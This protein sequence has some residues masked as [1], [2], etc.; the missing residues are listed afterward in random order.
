[1]FKIWK[2]IGKMDI[3][4]QKEMFATKTQSEVRRKKSDDLN[5]LFP[6]IFVNLGKDKIQ[7]I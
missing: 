2:G 7:R 5:T 1:M 6:Q 4:D 3:L